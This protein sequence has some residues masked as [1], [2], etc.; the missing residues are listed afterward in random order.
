MDRADNRRQLASMAPMTELT[1]NAI[2]VSR[3]TS[4][5]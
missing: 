2:I 5:K 1:I 4:E 3:R